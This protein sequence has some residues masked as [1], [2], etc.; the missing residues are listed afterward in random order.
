MTQC[1][2]SLAI[3]IF[4]RRY[5]L[6]SRW[7]NTFWAPLLSIV[8]LFPILYIALTSFDVLLG[9][10]GTIEYIFKGMLFGSFAIGFLG[11][12]FIKLRSPDT[13][14]G[15]ASSLGDQTD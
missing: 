11:A 6:D 2:A 8:G 14:A 3:F 13:Y 12:Y 5:K 1:I 15:M 4:F 9:V 10:K 7:W